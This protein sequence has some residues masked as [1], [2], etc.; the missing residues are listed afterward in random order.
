MSDKT[1]KDQNAWLLRGFILLVGILFFGFCYGM[2]A[3][4]ADSWDSLAARFSDTFGP[5]SFGLVV[6]SITKLWLLGFLPP[7]LRDQIVHWRIKNPLP[8]SKAFSK[9][10][11]NDQRVDLVKLAS[12]HGV[13]PIEEADQGRLFYRIYKSVDGSAGV[14]DA[15]RSYLAAR[16]CATMAFL[17]LVILTPVVYWI[18]QDAKS[19]VTFGII[20]IVTFVMMSLSAQTYSV[21]FVQNVLAQASAKAVP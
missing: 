2:P 14:D 16:D 12:D 1:L 20:L 19:A 10:G 5:A 7:R 13:L 4:C 6:L 8:G 17:F 18:S 21:R 3:I 11:P 9:I 15:H